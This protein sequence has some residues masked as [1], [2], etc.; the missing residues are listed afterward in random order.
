MWLFFRLRITCALSAVRT[1]IK[2]VDISLLQR[3]YFR[4]QFHLNTSKLI[5]LRAKNIAAEVFFLAK[6]V[7]AAFKEAFHF[8]FHLTDLQRTLDVSS[9]CPG[10]ELQ[11]DVLF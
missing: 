8:P 9:G 1:F 4:L 5:K 10:C 6:V 7:A 11:T 3:S 2:K